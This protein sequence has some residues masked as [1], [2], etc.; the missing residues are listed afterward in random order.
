MSSIFIRCTCDK[1]SEMINQQ[2][3]S[4]KAHLVFWFGLLVAKWSI[5]AN[6]KL[7]SE[8]T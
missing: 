4:K 5:R 1:N 2:L 7:L 3:M 8:V 6:R